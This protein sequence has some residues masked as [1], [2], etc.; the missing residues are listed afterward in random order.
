MFLGVQARPAPST[1]ESSDL[2]SLLSPGRK[3][4]I[5]DSLRNNLRGCGLSAR[6]EGPG[7]RNSPLDPA[8]TEDP[9]SV[10]VL[11]LP[12]LG[13]HPRHSVDICRTVSLIMHDVV[14]GFPAV[15][16]GGRRQMGER[17]GEEFRKD[18]HHLPRPVNAG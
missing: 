12:Y 2:G 18:F 13:S 16:E 14:I 1:A 3:N 6:K 4:I 10:L 5:G 11:C 17:I 15:P 8:P 7:K 9:L